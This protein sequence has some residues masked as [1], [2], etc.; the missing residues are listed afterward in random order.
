MGSSN[1]TPVRT[2]TIVS[3]CAASMVGL[4]LVAAWS[5]AKP[6]GVLCLPAEGVEEDLAVGGEEVEKAKSAKLEDPAGNPGGTKPAESPVDVESPVGLKQLLATGILA[7]KQSKLTEA[8][9]TL[10][11]ATEMFP[12]N[13]AAHYF[14]GTALL[15]KR[16][17]VPRAVAQVGAHLCCHLHRPVWRP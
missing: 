6:V 1:S 14:L 5:R 8:V 3:L 4:A 2:T 10:T 7:I 12:D 13:D 17:Y 11:Q 9:E 15:K 16:Q